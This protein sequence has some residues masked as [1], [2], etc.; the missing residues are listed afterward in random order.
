MKAS[1]EQVK[2]EAFKLELQGLIQNKTLFLLEKALNN[3]KII[4]K[5]NNDNVYIIK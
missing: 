5:L 2:R 4:V 1:K 3:G